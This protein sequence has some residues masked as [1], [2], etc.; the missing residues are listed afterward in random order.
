MRAN[1][2]LNL[3]SPSV[4]APAVRGCVYVVKDLEVQ[5]AGDGVDIIED[6]ADITVC[7][8][9]EYAR[10][11][12]SFALLDVNVDGVVDL[13]VGHPYS[14]AE[15]LQYH[16]GVSVYLGQISEGN[17]SLPSSPQLSI[18]CSE[19]PCG[20][21]GV[22]AQSDHSVLVGAP[23]AGAGGRMKGAVLEVV[24]GRDWEEGREYRVPGDLDWLLTGSQ[25][26][27]Q[28][29]SSLSTDQDLV[30]VGS[31]SYRIA[32]NGDSTFSSEDIEMAG[33]V[34]VVRLSGQEVTPLH[35]ETGGSQAS[36]LGTSTAFVEMKVGG[37]RRR[38]LAMGQPSSDSTSDP[39]HVQ[40]GS[41]LLKDISGTDQQNLTLSGN[42]EVGRFGLRLT[43]G[44]EEGLLV[45]A[46]YA[47]LGLRNH[48]QVYYYSGDLPSG[49]VTSHC[50]SSSSPCTEEWARLVL[51]PEEEESLFGSDVSWDS[52][53]PDTLLAVAAERSSLGSRMG[54][55]VY[56]YIVT[57]S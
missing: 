33:E 47:G 12:T 54:G 51:T 31:P 56:L 48:G 29:G 30:A 57:Q 27:Q 35:Q 16:G 1:S 22:M 43:G 45:S 6:I 44:W 55:T 21:G 18:V 26:F 49:D 52:S 36:A 9:E 17:F 50:Q 15:K 2:N 23:T 10:F 25:D 41:V 11:G 14:G 42:R 46:P 24:A 13:L 8:E 4:S 28:F 34:V 19:H 38:Y 20:L 53:G 3:T 7:S 37:E 39:D 40:T 32:A 5:L